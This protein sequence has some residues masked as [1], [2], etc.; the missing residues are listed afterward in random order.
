MGKAKIA[1]PCRSIKSKLLKIAGRGI[2]KKRHQFRPVQFNRHSPVLAKRHEIKARLTLRPPR[3]DGIPILDSNLDLVPDVISC[4]LWNN[5]RHKRRR[6]TNS[7]IARRP[8]KRGGAFSSTMTSIA[9]VLRVGYGWR[10]CILGRLRRGSIASAMR[11]CSPAW[12][13]VRSNAAGIAAGSGT[14]RKK[15]VFSRGRQSRRLVHPRLARHLQPY[16][17]RNENRFKI[18]RRQAEKVKPSK[19]DER[20]AIGDQTGRGHASILPQTL[21]WNSAPPV[22]GA[23][24]VRRSFR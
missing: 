18:P 20:P 8:R 1:P 10:Y 24:P 17:R 3:H 23:G 2:R 12:M 13:L 4:A 22:S 16:R 19:R 6:D 15:I 11:L 9:N 5:R 21:P 7:Q 14:T